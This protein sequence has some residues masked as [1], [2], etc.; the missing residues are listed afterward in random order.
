LREGFLEAGEVG[1]DAVQAG[2]GEDAQD[3]GAGDD[4]RVNRGSPGG[5]VF[6]EVSFRLCTSALDG[7]GF[8]RFPWPVQSAEPDWGTHP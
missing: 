2:E 3:G 6:D 7:S 5:A 8:T 1:D 4:Q